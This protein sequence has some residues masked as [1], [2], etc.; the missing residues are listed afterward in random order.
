[1][2]RVLELAA[3]ESPGRFVWISHVGEICAGAL[4]AHCRPSGV[5]Q[6]FFRPIYS[7]TIWIFERLEGAGIPGAKGRSCPRK[8][9]RETIQIGEQLGRRDSAWGT[10]GNLLPRVGRAAVSKGDGGQGNSAPRH[11][12]PTIGTADSDGA[13][14][15]PELRLSALRTKTFR[16]VS[17]LPAREWP[18]RPQH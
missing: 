18:P 16:D 1:M 4:N 6:H 3:G 15:R 11:G 17:P 9:T 10:G 5:A 2:G 7:E 8:W 14:R 12:D 13:S